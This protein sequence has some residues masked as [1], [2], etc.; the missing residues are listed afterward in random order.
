MLFGE[1]V[2]LLL[3]NLPF[4]TQILNLGVHTSRAQLMNAGHGG[5]TE[6]SL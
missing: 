6:L 4:G 3:L 5:W 1:I 2:V